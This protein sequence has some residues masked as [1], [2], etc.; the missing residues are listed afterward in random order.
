MGIS[1]NLEYGM[2]A[3]IS[4]VGL[5][6]APII[7]VLLRIFN[8]NGFLIAAVVSIL[9]IGILIGIGFYLKNDFIP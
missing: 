8:A 5:M 3:L 1:L 7:G 2:K 4:A 6:I 9:N